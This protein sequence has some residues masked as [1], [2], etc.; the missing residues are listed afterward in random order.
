MLLSGWRWDDGDV[1]EVVTHDEVLRW[2][3]REVQREWADAERERE[4]ATPPEQRGWWTAAEA[5]GY[6]GDL[7]E[8]RDLGDPEPRFL[9]CDR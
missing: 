2:L 9:R 5:A 8:V 4:M 1:D 7:V 3:P 6:D